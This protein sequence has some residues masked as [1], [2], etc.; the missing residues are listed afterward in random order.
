MLNFDRIYPI[1]FCFFFISFVI[2]TIE[3]IITMH[4]CTSQEM[5]AFQKFESPSLCESLS[6]CHL[7]RTTSKITPVFA[8]LS[9]GVHP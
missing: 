5:R 1:V 3:M 6:L 2:V 4:L 7:H 8:T 9:R